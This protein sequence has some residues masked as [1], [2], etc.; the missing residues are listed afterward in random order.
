MADRLSE[1]RGIQKAIVSALEKGEDV[2]ELSR[3]LA[4]VRAEIA[5]EVEVE[6]LKKVATEREELRNQAEAVKAR[7]EKQRVAIAA[8]LEA[9]DGVVDEMLPFLEKAKTLVDL[10]G[11]CYEQYRRAGDLVW[12]TSLPEGYLPKELTVPVLEGAD[13]VTDA[14]DRAS[15][16]VSYITAGLGLLQNLQRVDRPFPE[17]P[18]T[19][20]EGE[21]GTPEPNC[22]G[23]QHS[24][25][26][27]I[28]KALQAGRPL[29]GLEDEFSISRSTLSRHR[30]RC[31]NLGPIRMVEQV[32]PESSASSANQTFF[33]G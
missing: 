8:F 4:R 31:L 17:R 23:C 9:R 1:I 6:E 24:R 3:R 10:Q 27:E 28:N 25:A 19:E 11:K 33:H 12:T 14:Q 26:E 7:V 18:A 32:E 29:R 20:F 15:Q 16:A 2:A 5:A 30:G 13:K 21:L 22:L